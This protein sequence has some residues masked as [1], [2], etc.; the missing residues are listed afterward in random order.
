MF[1]IH[2]ADVI[3]GIE[4]SQGA[5]YG[6][7]SYNDEYGTYLSKLNGA[8]AMI[9]Q[10]AKDTDNIINDFQ[11]MFQPGMDAGAVLHDILDR[12]D[13][14]EDDL[15]DDDIRRLNETIQKIYNHKMRNY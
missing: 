12:R 7:P 14:S 9:M 15:M 10:S 4:F 2:G 5:F 11:R 3:D 8:Q 6:M 13:I 1:T